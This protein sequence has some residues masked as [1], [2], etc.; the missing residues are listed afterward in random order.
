[1]LEMR[2]QLAGNPKEPWIASCGTM[3]CRMWF[4]TTPC[5]SWFFNMAKQHH[6]PCQVVALLLAGLS[7]KRS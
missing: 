3:R 4:L 1:V 5:D 2:M 6:E 7:S